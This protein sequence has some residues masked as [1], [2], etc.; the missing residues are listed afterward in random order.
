MRDRRCTMTKGLTIT[1]EASIDQVV[2]GKLDNFY[3]ERPTLVNGTDERK[4]WQ[5]SLF[6]SSSATLDMFTRVVREC[7]KT[8]RWGC[9]A[10]WFRG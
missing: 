2:V 4:D 8:R 10:R 1:Q 6:S 5:H 9:D 7:R 3:R